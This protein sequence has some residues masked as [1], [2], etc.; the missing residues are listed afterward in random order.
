M[1]KT[2]GQHFSTLV[3]LATNMGIVPPLFGSTLVSPPAL[4][5]V[6]LYRPSCHLE[7]QTEH[8]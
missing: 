1:Q 5:I 3:G 6:T 8:S 4:H 7:S 2:F